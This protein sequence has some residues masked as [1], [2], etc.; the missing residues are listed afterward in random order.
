MNITIE[1]LKDETMVEIIA[2]DVL[3][4]LNIEKNYDEYLAVAKL[5]IAKAKNSFDISRNVKVSTHVYNTA[6]YAVLDYRKKMIKKNYRFANI[7]NSN[8]IEDKNDIETVIINRLDRNFN[9]RIMNQAVSN[10]KY[11]EIDIIKKRFWMDKSFPEIAKSHNKSKQAIQQSL[12]KVLKKIEKFLIEND[13]TDF[14]SQ[15]SL[16]EKMS[17]LTKQEREARI[18]E[19]KEIITNGS[20]DFKVYDELLNLYMES[21][22]ADSY[23][24]LQK[25]IIP[26]FGAIADELASTTV[27]TLLANASKDDAKRLEYDK[28]ALLLEPENTTLLKNVGLSYF[29]LKDYQNASEFLSK[30]IE[31]DDR[32]VQAYDFLIKSLINL[33]RDKEAVMHYKKVISVFENIADDM[34]SIDLFTL[35]ADAYSVIKEYDKSLEFDKKAL[36]LEPKNIS[37]LKNVGLS[38]FLLADNKNAEKYLRE[39]IALAP[40]DKESQEILEQIASTN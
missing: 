26:V 9:S 31:K 34:A 27:F 10:L 6:R 40:N 8:I 18:T 11:N 1:S 33:E 23:F 3:K 35:L 4:K 15:F 25:K 14:T 5:G 24:S 30:V 38:H 13:F 21:K 12:K 32:N 16:E 7:E 37:L 2:R 29:F 28:K 36:L 19:L 39:V 22:D 17:K 20:K